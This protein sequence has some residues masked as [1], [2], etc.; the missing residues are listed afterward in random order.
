MNKLS[1]IFHYKTYSIRQ[2]RI[3][4]KKGGIKMH[5]IYVMQKNHIYYV[6]AEAQREFNHMKDEVERKSKYI[7]VKV[8]VFRV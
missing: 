6:K 3:V 5:K 7:V 2:G 4:Y 8:K 1:N